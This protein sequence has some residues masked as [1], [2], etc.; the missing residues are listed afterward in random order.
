MILVGQHLSTDLLHVEG[1]VA[2][3]TVAAVVDGVGMTVASVVQNLVVLVV[4][5]GDPVFGDGR[6]CHTVD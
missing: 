4:G 6:R 5:V 2:Q 1:R 3:G